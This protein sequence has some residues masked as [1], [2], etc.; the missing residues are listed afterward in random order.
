MAKNWVLYLEKKRREAEAEER[1]RVFPDA[2]REAARYI[3]EMYGFFDGYATIIGEN[4]HFTFSDKTKITR[5][6]LPISKCIVRPG[7][8]LI[9]P[10]LEEELKKCGSEDVK[11]QLTH[12][13]IRERRSE[14]R[15]NF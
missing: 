12:I 2:C 13:H 15:L 3:K 5:I 10:Y 6:T 11:K 7:V 14:G 4:V 1:G 8:M 9:K